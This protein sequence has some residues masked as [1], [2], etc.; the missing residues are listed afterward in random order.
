[1]WSGL[2]HYAFV[3]H[4]SWFFLVRSLADT[5]RVLSA[6]EPSQSYNHGVGPGPVVSPEGSAGEG[7]MP[8]HLWLFWDCIPCWRP[9]FLLRGL[10]WEISSQHGSTCHHNQQGRASAGEIGVIILCHLLTGV[11]PITFATRRV[12]AQSC[13]TL[14]DPV[15]CNPPGSS[16]NF[17]GKK[18]WSR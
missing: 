7:F 16:G 15:D 12:C 18:Y 13:P 6:S 10:L 4:I 17:P 8:K 9:L 3:I 5:S 2:K 1:M 11:T 14:C